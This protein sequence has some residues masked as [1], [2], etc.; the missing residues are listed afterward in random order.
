MNEN[1]LEFILPIRNIPFD[2]GLK[3]NTEAEK[4]IRAYISNNGYKV[5]EDNS[6][7]SNMSS[8]FLLA[9]SVLPEVNFYLYDFGIGVITIKDERFIIKDREKFADDYCQQ[10]KE[11]HNSILKTGSHKYSQIIESTASK[12]REIV[13]VNS[14]EEPRFTSQNDFENRGFSYVFTFSVLKQLP[15]REIEVNLFNESEIKNL[16]IMLE[17]GIA[18]KEDSL[19]SDTSVNPDPYDFDIKTYDMPKDWMKATN[20]ALYISWASVVCL[21]NSFEEADVSAIKRVEFM[22]IDLQAMWMY[23]YC[24]YL[25]LSN[26]K[27]SGKNA[28]GEMQK[29]RFHI[30]RKYSEFKSNNDS[31]ISKYLLDIRNELINTSDIQKQYDKFSE[32]LNYLLE[33]KKAKEDEYQH[34]YSAVSEVLLYALTF[35]SIA[36]MI[37]NFISG[38]YVNLHWPAVVTTV[39]LAI[40]GMIIIIKKE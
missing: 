20:Q 39:I 40:I 18:N 31:S 28:V 1:N 7:L 13:K 19:F 22:E 8:D 14:K 27:I 37:Y 25:V 5:I 17:P 38:N 35:L 12:L 21:V 2:L 30:N 4:N 36:P 11:A 16:L 3:I 24:L 9:F 23:I 34:R 26:K 15:G 33:E 6:V 10:R 32:Y 29:L